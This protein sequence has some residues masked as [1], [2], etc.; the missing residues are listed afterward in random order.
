MFLSVCLNLPGSNIT[1]PENTPAL[2]TWLPHGC[3]YMVNTGDRHV[4]WA[5]VRFIWYNS[6]VSLMTQILCKLCC[7][8]VL[9]EMFLVKS[10]L[11]SHEI[12]T[13]VA[14]VFLFANLLP[15]LDN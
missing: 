14:N 5:S 12:P 10:L 4:F 13:N 9:K 6:R 8:T 1:N 15:N 7:Q 11:T 2:S 3:T